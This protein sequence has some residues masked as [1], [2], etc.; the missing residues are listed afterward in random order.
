MLTR[1]RS[2]LFKINGRHLNQTPLPRRARDWDGIELSMPPG[3]PK[4][5]A[6]EGG[7][8][9]DGP[10][11][12]EGDRI[13]IWCHETEGGAG[14]TARARVGQTMSTDG[15]K[16]I[17]PVDIEILERK[18]GY[19][20]LAGMTKTPRVFEYTHGYNLAAVYFLTEEDEQEIQDAISEREAVFRALAGQLEQGPDWSSLLRTRLAKQ[21]DDLR[22]RTTDA[23]AR[24]GQKEFRA[25]VFDACGGQCVISG[26]PVDEALEAAH[27]VPF[28]GDPE[29]DHPENGLALRRDLHALFD[30]FLL[31]MNPKTRN[32][33][34][35]PH[36]VGEDPEQF[37]YAHLSGTTIVHRAPEELLRVHCDAFRE[38]WSQ[39]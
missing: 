24:P 28:N 5:P 1:M 19:K 18:I 12:E 38:K 20:D 30:R 21:G 37:P 10:E 29:W 39:E 8:R 16:S 35:A 4:L 34:L 17:R 13:W 32:I 7:R 2:F 26:C 31:T 3:G 36:L 23:V 11:I 9:P 33:E 25:K 27:I 14:L 6:S 15:D 22:M